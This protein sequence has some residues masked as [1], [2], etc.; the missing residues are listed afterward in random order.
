MTVWAMSI[1]L[2]RLKRSAR[3]PAVREKKRRG[4]VDEATIRPTHVFEPVSSNISHEA[5]TVWTNVPDE[6]KTLPAQSQRKLG[7]LSGSTA[8]DIS[9]A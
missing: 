2:A 8:D 9:A 3:A 7:Y 4:R 5:A 6:D 1:S